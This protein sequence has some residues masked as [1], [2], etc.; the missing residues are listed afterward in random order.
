MRSASRPR[1]AQPYF[2][3]EHE[4]KESLH[5]SQAD[6]CRLGDLTN[7]KPVEQSRRRGKHVGNI[8]PA[9]QVELEEARDTAR[10]LIL[11]FAESV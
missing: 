4:A 3:G 5:I 9:S 7:A 11:A 1:R 10:R 2:G 8:G 6:L